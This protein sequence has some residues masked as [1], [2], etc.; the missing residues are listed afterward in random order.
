MYFKKLG[1]ISFFMLMMCFSVVSNAETVWIDVRSAVEHSIDNIEGDARIS[2]DDIVAGVS[3]I[4]PDK[5]TEI[6][7]YCRSG[8]RAGKAILALK[9]DGYTNVSNAGGIND[10]RRE[11]GLN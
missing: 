10:A 6:R 2:H 1:Y 9:E 5:N 7:L 3:E 8:N 11:R 4:F